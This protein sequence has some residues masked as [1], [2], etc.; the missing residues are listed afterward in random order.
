[1]KNVLY[2]IMFI[3][4]LVSFSNIEGRAESHYQNT[5]SN[6]IF[7]FDDELYF[8]N[9]SE[10]KVAYKFQNNEWI[11]LDSEFFTDK[12][13]V[14]VFNQND[15]VMFTSTDTSIYLSNDFGDSWKN[16]D[17]LFGNW[18]AKLSDFRIVKS[19]IESEI[20]RNYLYTYPPYPNPAKSE[21]KVLFFWDINLPMTTEDISI[22]DITGKKIDAYDNISLVK[23][24]NHYGNLIWN[25]SNAQ[26][27]IYLINIKHGT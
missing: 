24:A 25:C 9:F 2:I 12:G 13:L 18:R 4:P 27:G 22:Y 21:V 10:I 15:N 7:S 20:E 11:R 23:Q 5:S 3:V 8:I 19:S 1:M 26:P 16:F 14:Q 6:F 17:T